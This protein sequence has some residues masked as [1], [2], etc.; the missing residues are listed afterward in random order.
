VLLPGWPIMVMSPRRPRT[1]TLSE[2]PECS[3]S[4]LAVGG[5]SGPQDP[6]TPLGPNH[7]T[8]VQ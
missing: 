1:H 7:V 8:L 6:S 3:T 5:D 2:S 4:G